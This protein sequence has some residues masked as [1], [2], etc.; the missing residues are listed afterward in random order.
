MT[1][2]EPLSPLKTGFSVF[3]L[4]KNVGLTKEG[5]KRVLLILGLE[6]I[7]QLSALPILVSGEEGL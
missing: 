3:G 4:H 7:K 2:R 1:S 5:V 6:M